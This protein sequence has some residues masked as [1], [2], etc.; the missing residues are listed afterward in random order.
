MHRRHLGCGALDP[1]GHVGRESVEQ[2]RK[3][4]RPPLGRNEHRHRRQRLG[5]RLQL[6][7]RADTVEKRNSLLPSRLRPRSLRLLWRLLL[8]WLLHPRFRARTLR[9]PQISSP[10]RRTNS[11]RRF[12]NSACRHTTCSSDSSCS[13]SACAHTATSAHPYQRANKFNRCVYCLPNYKP[14]Y[15]VCTSA[16]LFARLPE[17]MRF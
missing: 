9:T 1:A 13:Q 2:R 11:A 3:L 8:L 4:S 16:G 15:L 7:A 17:H 14:I 5:A 10:Q 6:G 12:S